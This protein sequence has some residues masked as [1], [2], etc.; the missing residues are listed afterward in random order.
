MT[1]IKFRNRLFAFQKL[2]KSLQFHRIPSVKICKQVLFVLFLKKMKNHRKSIPAL[3]TL[4]YLILILFSITSIVSA[5]DSPTHDE[6]E[7]GGADY[8]DVAETNIV[9][10]FEDMPLYTFWNYISYPRY[11][12]AYVNFYA[13]NPA[14]T[15][16]IGNKLTEYSTTSKYIASNYGPGLG[17]INAIFNQP[18]H[19]LSF[20]TVGVNGGN[21]KVNIYQN[22]VFTQQL[23]LPAYCFPYVSCFVDLGSYNNV[24]A[25]E[26][27][28]INDNYGLGFDDFSFALGGT[29]P[30]PIPTPTPTPNQ[31]PVGALEQVKDDGTAVGW[32]RDPDNLN[33][34]NVVQFYVDGAKGVGTPVG[35]ARADVIRS[36]VGN[37]GFEFSIPVKY[38]DGKPHTLYAYGQD[39]VSGRPDTLLTGS[40]KSFNI[41]PSI[42]KVVFEPITDEVIEQQFT[43]SEVD[44]ATG[45]GGQ[46]IFP[47]AKQPDEGINR[48][49]VRVKVTISP[50]IKDVR[51]YFKNFD[52]DDPSTDDDPVDDNGS[53]GNDNREGRIVNYSNP[54]PYPASAA[55]ILSNASALTDASGVA[56]V[57]FSVTKQ[58]GDNFVIAAS[59]D[60]TYL[61]G[62]AVNGA[63]LKDSTNNAL[64]TMKAGRTEMLTVW[65]KIHLEVD[66]M[67]AV[68]NNV[69]YGSYGSRNNV[70]VGQN[71]VW[72]PIFLYS[73]NLEEHRYRATYD[74]GGTLI[75]YGGLLS[76]RGT[77][78]LKVLD[79]TINSVLVRSDNGFVTVNP[80]NSLVLFDDDD[81]NSNDGLRWHGDNGE[82]VSAL[83]D[84]FSHLQPSSN[85]NEN[86]FAAAYIEPDYM[87]AARQPG[88]NDTDVLFESNYPDSRNSVPERVKI[89]PYRDSKNSERN[90][91]WVGY[92]LIAYQSATNVDND[93]L[94]IDGVDPPQPYGWVGGI[95]PYFDADFDF[96]D[97]TLDSTGVPRGAIGSIFY[98]EAM[99]DLDAVPN[100]N[101]N[102][103][104]YQSRLRTAPHELG[105]Q[106]GIRGD[107]RDSR[108]GVMSMEGFS[109]MIE[110]YSSYINLMRWRIKSPGEVQ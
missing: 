3:Q 65:R 2:Y 98:I 95:S 90:D 97:G 83:Y 24:T 8:Y 41:R 32:S 108:L 106:F 44:R 11:G 40:P 21:Y 110:F 52:V 38:R 48:K 45:F 73:E 71:S 94:L 33:V 78:D 60:N 46:R 68:A 76:V 86:P 18:V 89:E 58:P 51:V 39:I 63:G 103:F 34:A 107:G 53:E 101:L 31:P 14:T 81:F 59:T 5:Q 93:P 22:Q 84:T 29:A 79:N 49:R 16:Y 70:I 20:L 87:W 92:F 26:I 80:R 91:F 88:M 74:S 67:G 64:P 28:S 10:G 43:H 47:D 35:Q 82:Y 85:V 17:G 12:N 50:A 27:H 102:Q 77:D 25:I 100:P 109:M 55:G 66:S 13:Q 30:T 57:Y 61:G 105:H 7:M 75:S 104:P 1:K 36:D 6:P 54:Q 99:R 72:I 56:F 69:V 4:H 15:I 42:D 96:N 19:N 9:D 23:T 62:V 37:H